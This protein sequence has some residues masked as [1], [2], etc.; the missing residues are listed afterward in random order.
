MG[1]EY[2]SHQKMMADRFKHVRMNKELEDKYKVPLTFN[3]SVGFKV[4][5]PRHQELLKMTRHP[6]TKCP[7]TRYADEM[8]RTGFPM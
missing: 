2:S 1:K 4:T 5:D 3:Q 8:I 6:I 7:E